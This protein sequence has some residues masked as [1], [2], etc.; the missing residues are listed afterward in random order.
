MRRAT[1]YPALLV[2]LFRL[3]LAAEVGWFL[4]LVMEA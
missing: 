1:L 2:A 3:C 4:W